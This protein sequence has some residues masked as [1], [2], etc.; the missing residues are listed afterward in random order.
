[1]QDS[2]IKLAHPVL[3]WFTE[4]LSNYI[5]SK[6][7]V[8]VRGISFKNNYPFQGNDAEMVLRQTPQYDPCSNWFILKFTV[9]VKFKYECDRITLFMTPEE[10]YGSKVTAK[11]FTCDWQAVYAPDGS[12]K[13]GRWYTFTIVYKLKNDNN[14]CKESSDG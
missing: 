10:L 12:Y 3:H 9:K 6:F 13:P 1:M 8:C 5:P 7:N 14:L 4:L 2:C 11:E